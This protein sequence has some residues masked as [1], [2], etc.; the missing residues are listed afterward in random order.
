MLEILKSWI[1]TMLCTGIFFTFVKMIVPNSKLSKYIYSLI[2]VVTIFTLVVPTVKFINTENLENSTKSVIN[3]IDGG[4]S[5]VDIDNI[6]AKNTLDKNVKNEFAKKMKNSISELLEKNNIDVNMITVIVDD[7][8][9]IQKVS[10]KIEN[11][12]KN[13]LNKMEKIFSLIKE[14]YNISDEKVVIEEV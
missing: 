4:T 14:N 9:Q 8:Y 1:T 11:N 10:I 7:N 13:K 5:V 3:N 6:D 2:G 12:L